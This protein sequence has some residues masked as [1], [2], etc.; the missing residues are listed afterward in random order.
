M[1]GKVFSNAKVGGGIKTVDVVLTLGTFIHTERGHERFYPVSNGG[2]G[3]E[4]RISHF[5]IFFPIFN[6]VT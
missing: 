4:P 6:T 2:Q 5:S 3:S 1:T